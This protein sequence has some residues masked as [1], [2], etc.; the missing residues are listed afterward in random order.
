MSCYTHR[1]MY[2]M[3]LGEPGE[4]MRATVELQ[5]IRLGLA[6][7]CVEVVGLQ[8]GMRYCCEYP[9]LAAGSLVGQEVWGE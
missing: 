1:V 7:Q 5:E 9:S 2:R 6:F 8:S 3:A 4:N